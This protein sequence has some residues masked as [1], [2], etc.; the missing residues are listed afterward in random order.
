MRDTQRV[1]RNKRR[2]GKPENWRERAKL[3]GK[4]TLRRFPLESPQH[5]DTDGASLA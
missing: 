2:R 4:R 1:E 3:S 5:G